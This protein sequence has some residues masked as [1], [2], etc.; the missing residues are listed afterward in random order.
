MSQP[1]AE[2][3]EQ[4][5]LPALFEHC[6]NVYKQMEAEAKLIPQGDVPPRSEM[7][8]LIWEGYLTKLFASLHLSVP[9]YTSVTRELKRMGCVRQKRRGGGNAPSQ[10]E[11][12]TE[13]TE[14]LFRSDMNRTQGL[15]AKKR[16]E[17]AML[18]QQVHDMS[19]RLSKVEADYEAIIDILVEKEKA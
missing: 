16:G 13:P 7:H 3:V 5:T 17:S 12:V 4:D 8:Q 14:E 18:R 6:Q 19:L 11:I 2:P 9:Y 10:W 1:I 15:A